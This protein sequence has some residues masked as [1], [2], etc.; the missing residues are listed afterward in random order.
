MTS[1]IALMLLWVTIKCANK[2]E[3]LSSLIQMATTHLLL[4]FPR[5]SLLKY[6]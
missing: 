2:L 6:L 4:K 3:S 5:Q 1:I